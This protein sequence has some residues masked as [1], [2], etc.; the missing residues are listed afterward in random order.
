MTCPTRYAAT[1]V[2]V[3]GHGVA[4]AWAAC[5]R[6]VR[7]TGS[8][9]AGFLRGSSTASQFVRFTFVGGVSSAVYVLLFLLLSGVDA[10]TANLAGAIGSTVLANELHRLLTF[11]AGGRVTW[12]TAQLEGGGLAVV[13][14][15]ATSVG[16][17]ALTQVVGETSAVVQLLLIGAVTGSIG[18]VRFVALRAWVFKPAPATGAPA[19]EQPS[20]VA[21]P[22]ASAAR[23]PSPQSTRPELTT[24]GAR[25]G[26]GRVGTGTPV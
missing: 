10:Q 16:L 25:T 22:A 5:S 1:A 19:A 21:V 23:V 18:L 3:L 8:R 24:V 7:S 4:R 11:Q 12:L 26:R 6:A 15:V 13:G 17:A 2:D 14:L 9:V 20:P